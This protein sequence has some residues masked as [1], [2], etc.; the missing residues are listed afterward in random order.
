MEMLRKICCLW[1]PSAGN[2]V[3]QKLADKVKYGEQLSAIFNAGTGTEADRG[4]S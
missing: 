3:E 4:G 2:I 1:C